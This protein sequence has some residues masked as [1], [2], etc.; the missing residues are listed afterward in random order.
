[1]R[2]E[3]LSMTV[4]L[5]SKNKELVLP[6]EFQMH[7]EKLLARLDWNNWIGIQWVESNEKNDQIKIKFGKFVILALIDQKWTLHFFHHLFP[8]AH[9]YLPKATMSN[10]YFKSFRIHGHGQPFIIEWVK[11][12]AIENPLDAFWAP[13]FD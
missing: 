5:V 8:H 2:V 12:K 6:L 7:L 11:Q 9:T 3:I 1:M 13:S 4:N 10:S